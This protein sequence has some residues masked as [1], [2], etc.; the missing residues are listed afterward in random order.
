MT[1]VTSCF[2]PFEREDEQVILDKRTVR[3]QK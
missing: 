3:E 1:Y 2:L